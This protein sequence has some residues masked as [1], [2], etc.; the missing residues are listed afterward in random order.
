MLR[1]T[2]QAQ[3]KV[4]ENVLSENKVSLKLQKTKTKQKQSKKQ[5]TKEIKFQRTILIALRA[6]FVLMSGNENVFHG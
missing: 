3:N 4:S 6:S 1:S 5:K 2:F